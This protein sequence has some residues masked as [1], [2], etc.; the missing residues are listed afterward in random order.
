M[1]LYK[2]ISGNFCFLRFGFMKDG[3]FTEPCYFR[4]PRHAPAT[5][6]TCPLPPSDHWSAVEQTLE[7]RTPTHLTLNQ[8]RLKL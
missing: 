6:Y 4:Q 1:Q 3:R 7:I 8:R 5:Q 2:I